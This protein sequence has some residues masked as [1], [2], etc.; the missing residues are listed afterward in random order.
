MRLRVVSWNVDSRPTGLLDA[1]VDLL[2]T[3]KPDLAILQ[4]INRPVYRALLPHPSAHERMHQR[5]R[6]FS[7]GALSTDLSDPRGS[8]YRLG[9]AVLGTP[10]TARLDARV[11]TKA[12]FEVSDPAR[13][14]MLW[15]TVAT[16]VALSTGAMLTVGSFHGRQS[17]AEEDQP[18]G[19]PAAALQ[20]AFHT[21]I[22]GWLARVAGPIVFGIDVGIPVDD[23]DPLL[24][25][26]RSHD[27]IAISDGHPNTTRDH[28]WAT[29]DLTVLDVQ[30]LAAEAAATGSDHPLLFAELE[31][32]AQ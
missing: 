27:L 32:R 4:E 30:C 26:H 1:K 7:W 2:R 9:C 24:G 20:R 23:S 19:P 22:A 10:N 6:L 28:L 15:R 21:G 17:A 18:A 14:A 25:P 12:S 13:P 3:L 31:L 8:E 29:A 11:L 16:T 5:P